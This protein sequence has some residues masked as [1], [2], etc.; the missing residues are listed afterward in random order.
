MGV[1]RGG[2][3][4]LFTNV[5]LADDRND[6]SA[7]ISQM[8]VLFSMFHNS[9]VD[10]LHREHNDYEQPALGLQYFAALY[11]D[12]KDICVDV[13]RR[14]VRNDLLRRLL[15]PAVY[16]HYFSAAPS[17]LDRQSGTHMT[18]EYAQALRFGHAMV[19]PHYRINDVH[20]RREEL[21]DVLLTTS[22]ARPWRLPLDESW[23][24]QWSKFFAVAGQPVNFSRRIGPHFSADLVSD[25]AF[26]GIDETNSAG[27]AYRDLLNA[28]SLPIWSVRSLIAEISRRGFG[29]I[30]R[31]RLWDPNYCESALKAWLADGRE[32]SGGLTAEDIEIVSRDPPL[33][34]FVLFEAASEMGGQPLGLWLDSHRRTDRKGSAGV[35]ARRLHWQD[36]V[37]SCPDCRHARAGDV[38]TLACRA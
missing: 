18:L 38:R 30:A 24:V 22:R 11:L 19:R 6:N 37:R 21:I 9:V 36:G 1:P 3:D 17:F 29:Q 12:A 16:A 15:H 23:A 10:L 5:L 28:A 32:G 8:T 34:L 31:S 13:Y 27:L 35:P 14:I 26:A 4:P 25:L 7:L 20:N 2:R 33:I